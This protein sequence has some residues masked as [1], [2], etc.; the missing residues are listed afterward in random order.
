MS[1]Q[2]TSGAVY[3]ESYKRLATLGAAVTLQGKLSAL[4][5][6]VLAGVTTV[7]TGGEIDPVKGATIAVGAVGAGTSSTLT[8]GGQG[9]VELT[10]TLAATVTVTG[11]VKLD[12][13]FNGTG[14]LTL[15]SG[16]ALTSVGVDAYTGTVTVNDGTLLLGG[17]N[18]LG[19]NALTLGSATQPGSV[20]LLGANATLGN[21]PVTVAGGTADVA[22]TLTFGG[23]VTLNGGTLSNNP[24]SKV[25]FSSTVTFNGGNEDQSDGKFIFQ[26]TVTIQQ[27]ALTL[28]GKNIFTGALTLT[29]PTVVTMA[30][31]AN[32]SIPGGLAGGQSLEIVASPGRTVKV[33]LHSNIGTTKLIA[34]DGTTIKELAGFP[35]TEEGQ[36]SAVG[37]GVVDPLK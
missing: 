24:A 29:Q 14:S 13:T 18:P 34:G 32:V 11:A 4:N 28:A 31:F 16:A 1:V 23:P 20:Q 15:N 25:T 27:A 9:T 35:P 22:G 10:G 3:L 6:V 8:V 26:Q 36:V 12:T 37:T 17:T 21:S 33:R 30:P 2:P 19:T 5:S 7:N